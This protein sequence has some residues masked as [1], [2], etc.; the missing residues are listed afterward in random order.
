MRFS[1][2]FFFLLIDQIKSNAMNKLRNI[3]MSCEVLK[4]YFFTHPQCT[5]VLELIVAIFKLLL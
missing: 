2:Y 4:F 3:K 5:L 1:L